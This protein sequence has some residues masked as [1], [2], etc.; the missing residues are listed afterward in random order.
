MLAVVMASTAICALGDGEVSSR[1]ARC[2]DH[3]GGRKNTAGTAGDAEGIGGSAWVAFLVLYQ[4]IPNFS[5]AWLRSKER[6]PAAWRWR[7]KSTHVPRLN[8]MGEK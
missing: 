6:R 5:R 8:P 2:G 3:V 7:L 1:V 4:L